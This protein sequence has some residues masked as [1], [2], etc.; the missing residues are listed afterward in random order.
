MAREPRDRQHR[1]RSLELRAFCTEGAG[2]EG[3]ASL[4]AFERLAGGLYQPPGDAQGHWQAR[5][6]AVPMPGGAPQWWLH[7]QARAPVVLQCQRCLQPLTHELRIDRRFRFVA[8]EDEAERLDEQIDDDVLV[9]EPRFDLMALLEDE[10]LLALPLVPRHEPDCP[11]PLDAPAGEPA[12]E[13]EPERPNPFAAL[14]A[15]RRGGGQG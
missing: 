7:L 14:A 10:L 4:A 15:L 2:L 8:N 9:L 13:A 5:G 11:E 1:P 12:D 6:E 3:Q